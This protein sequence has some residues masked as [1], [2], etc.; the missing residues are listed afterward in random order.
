MSARQHR[1]HRIGGL[2]EF[3]VIPIAAISGR[4]ADEHLWFSRGCA[5][6]NYFIK[7]NQP[8]FLFHTIR[9]QADTV[10]PRN[11]Q[12]IHASGEAWERQIPRF[13]PRLQASEHNG[14]I[15]CAPECAGTFPNWLQ[16]TL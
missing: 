6:F 2:A 5:I 12:G 11:S 15:A 13:Y 7:V 4:T 8:G 14:S 3:L 9:I 16:I 1:P 10:F